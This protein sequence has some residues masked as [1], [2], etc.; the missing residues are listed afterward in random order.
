MT[1]PLTI[2]RVRLIAGPPSTDG[3]R[4]QI[5]GANDYPIW[6]GVGLRLQ[7]GFFEKDGRTLIEDVSTISAATH[8]VTRSG[9]T[10]MT[11][12]KAGPFASITQDQWDAGT[13]QHVEF[14]FS[15]TQTSLTAATDYAVRIIGDDTDGLAAVD[16]CFGRPMTILDSGIP[17]SFTT[18]DNAATVL[19][20]MQAYLNAQLGLYAKKV[21]GPGE[22]LTFTSEDGTVKRQL[23]VT[24]DSALGAQRFDNIEIPS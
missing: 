5:E 15:D 21:M 24:N 10:Y 6:N 14:S 11:Q 18:P 16:F 2:I 13:H 19:A 7:C 1:R 3:S 20:Q 22:L 9:S 4:F 17:T 12:T 23:G 8:F